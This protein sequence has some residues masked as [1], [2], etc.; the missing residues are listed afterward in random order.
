MYI[1][2]DVHHG[3]GVEEA[4]LL[5]D[6]VMTLSLHKYGGDFF[7]GTGALSDVG[8]GEGKGYKVN[9][10]LSDGIGDAAYL[11]LFRSVADEACARFQPGAVVIQSGADSLA[12]DRLGVFNLSSRGHA[13]CHAHVRAWGLPTL[14]LGGG[15]YTI[16]NVA[17]CWTLETGVHLGESGCCFF[18]VFFPWGPAPLPPHRAFFRPLPH[19]PKNQH[20]PTKKRPLPGVEHLMSERLPANAYDEYYR[21]SNFALT[22]APDAGMANRNRRDALER[23]RQAVLETLRQNVRGGG[24]AQLGADRP[25]ALAAMGVDAVAVLVDGGGGGG[26]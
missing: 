24:G 10:P 7:P 18:C 21:P 14:V 15:G 22:V 11:E 8:V 12:G 25:E 2:I 3:D 5:T 13:A 26:G 1:D 19:L 17:R 20:P 6:R 23:T 16:S 4:F 9:V